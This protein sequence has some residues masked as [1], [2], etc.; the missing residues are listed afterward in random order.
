MSSEISINNSVSLKNLTTGYFGD[1]AFALPGVSEKAVTK[2]FSSSIAHG[3]LVYIIGP[4]GCGK[5]TLLK[6]ISGL[7]PPL[8][9][10]IYI[11]GQSIKE[12]SRDLAARK[13]SVVLTKNPDPGMFTAF[14]VVSMGRT[15]YTDWKHTLKPDD[16]EIINQSM[17]LTGADLFKETVF[18]RL[19]DGEKQKVIIARA[20]AQD[21]DIMCL[22]EP[23]SFLDLPSKA[24]L[25]GLLLKIKRR[26][27][28][29]LFVTS[30][31]LDS[32]LKFAD[33]LWTIDRNGEISAGV[34][35]D[36]ALDRTV[37]SV[38]SSK[39]IFFNISTGEFEYLALNNSRADSGN[40]ALSVN[41]SHSDGGKSSS[42]DHELSHA[43]YWTRRSLL[44]NGINVN[45]SSRGI[46]IT[47]REKESS[48]Y[49]WA[50]AGC[51]FDS[52]GN[53]VSW[54]KK[55]DF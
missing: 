25:S 34:P 29:T 43:V 22:D 41:L 44:R 42:A 16:M 31:D 36:L 23:A 40:T 47:I 17:A 33:T 1:K 18:S 27:G 51:V 32:A 14:D 6:T 2:S 49:E 7:I 10:N 28:K 46:K 19:S 37:G 38:F 55:Q 50:A 13:I 48:R 39:E 53:L 54:L 4:N 30:H 15:P 11:N 26:K 9:G 5:T 20:L 3:E 21:T 52:I 45:K 24:E 8:S 35:E 12:M